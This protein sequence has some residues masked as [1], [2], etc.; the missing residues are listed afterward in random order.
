MKALEAIYEDGN[1]RFLMPKEKGTY[2]AIVVL[3]EEISETRKREAALQKYKKLSIQSDLG[4]K[5]DSEY[6]N[7]LLEVH[8]ELAPLRAEV[9]QLL[10][11]QGEL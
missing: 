9:E 3:V 2:K 1:I 7:Q 8:Q 10:E 5:A 4:L 6:A 11:E